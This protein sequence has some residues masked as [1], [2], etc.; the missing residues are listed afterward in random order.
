MPL[1]K[2]S[3]PSN[4]RLWM[5]NVVL[6]LAPLSQIAAL[7]A[8]LLS[9]AKTNHKNP[10]STLEA[11]IS[12]LWKHRVNHP[13]VLI[14]M[15]CFDTHLVERGYRCQWCNRLWR[16]NGA[17]S[18]EWMPVGS[19]LFYLGFYTLPLPLLCLLYHRRSFSSA[20]QNVCSYSCCS[21][22]TWGLATW[23]ILPVLF[24][25]VP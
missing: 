22:V 12:V 3:Q 18:V 9:K 7:A 15:S 4:C 14:S 20:V 24:R 17:T 11:L 8:W 1:F 2:R 23:D 6:L 13:V 19:L 16:N 21:N 5:F 10:N 25:S